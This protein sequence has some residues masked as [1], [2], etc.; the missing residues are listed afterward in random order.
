VSCRS[1]A[2]HALARFGAQAAA[3]VP[4]LEEMKKQGGRDAAAADIALRQIAAVK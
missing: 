1:Y 3:A 4:L 2:A